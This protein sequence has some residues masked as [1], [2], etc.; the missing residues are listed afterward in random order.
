M[1][2]LHALLLLCEILFYN[3]KTNWEKEGKCAEKYYKLQYENVSV[4]CSIYIYCV[5]VRI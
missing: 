2:E 5:T 4:S 3:R 1:C